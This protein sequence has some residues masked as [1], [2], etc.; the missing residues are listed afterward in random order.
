M[1]SFRKM[2]LRQIFEIIYRT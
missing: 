1:E 2:R